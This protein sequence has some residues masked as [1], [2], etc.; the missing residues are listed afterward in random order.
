MKAHS[1]LGWI[2]AIG[3]LHGARD[4]YAVG[5]G[6]ATDQYPAVVAMEAPQPDGSFEKFTGVLIFSGAGAHRF[7]RDR[8]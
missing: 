4:A 3:V 8:R 5:H 7:A 6:T 2:V 1:I